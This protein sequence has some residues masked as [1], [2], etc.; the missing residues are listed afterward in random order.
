MSKVIDGHV[1]GPRLTWYENDNYKMTYE[2]IDGEVYIHAVV[3]NFSKSV[4]N[5]MREKWLA[6]KLKLYSL[7]YENVFTYTKDI[8]IVNLIE[9]GE[10]IG[11]TQ[12]LKVVR[13]ELV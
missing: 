4:L 7:G 11:E 1:V 13:W 3:D 5:D 8:R 12:G 10:M 9:A 6:F 2:V